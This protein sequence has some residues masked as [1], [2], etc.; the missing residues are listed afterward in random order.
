MKFLT[1]VTI[2]FVSLLL[3]N[4]LLAQPQTLLVGTRDPRV[5]FDYDGNMV[6]TARNYD[7]DYPVVA[8]KVDRKLRFLWPNEEYGVGLFSALTENDY[9]SGAKILPQKDGSVLFAGMYTK[10][11]RIQEPTEP[12]DE[13]EIIYRKYPILQLVDAAGNRQWGNTGICLSDT[14]FIG[15][16]NSGSIDI[17]NFSFDSE[18]NVVVI[19]NWFNAENEARNKIILGTFMQKVNPQTGEILLAPGGRKFLDKN[20]DLAFEMKDNKIFYLSVSEDG[21]D[22]FICADKNGE[23]LWSINLFDNLFWDTN[24]TASVDSNGDIYLVYASVDNNILGC[25]ITADGE[26]QNKDQL[27]VSDSHKVILWTPLFG[28][29]DDNWILYLDNKLY[30][31]TSEGIYNWDENGIRLSSTETASYQ[32]FDVSIDEEFFWVVYMT[33]MDSLSGNFKLKIQK[34]SH[35]GELLWDDDGIDLIYNCGASARILPDKKGG[36]Y[37]ICDAF[38]V[39]EPEF[40]PRGTLIMRLDENGQFSQGVGIQASCSNNIPNDFLLVNTFPNPFSDH[41]R[42]LI[43]NSKNVTSNPAS[44]TIYNILGKEVMRYDLKENIKN[45]TVE[46]TWDGK[47]RYGQKACPGVYFFQVLSGGSE[48]LGSGKLLLL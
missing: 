24:I 15:T 7:P 37:I 12:Y 46:L 17:L 5:K 19:W 25:K 43:Q 22:Q 45:S 31:F 33:L 8:Q 47:D 21:S 39:D 32:G 1:I 44:L 40:Q 23:T 2:Y 41:T 34:I 13:T 14:N 10:F 38:A 30:N 6:C 26:I 20:A 3:Q 42:F 36:A 29:E 16:D 28:W 9:V 48:R 27:I 11:L 18:G 35:S 4:N